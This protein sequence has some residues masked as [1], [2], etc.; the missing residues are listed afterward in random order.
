MGVQYRANTTQIAECDS[1]ISKYQTLPDD[2]ARYFDSLVFARTQ[3][4]A[5]EMDSLLDCKMTLI[6]ARNR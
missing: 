1:L 5:D 2:I 4:Y 3:K 6:E